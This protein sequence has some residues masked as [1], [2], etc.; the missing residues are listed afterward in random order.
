[1][2]TYEFLCKVCQKTFSVIQAMSEHGKAAIKC[3]HC[4]S[5]HVEQLFS[6]FFAKTES[7]S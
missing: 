7:K 1:M 5:S 6:G 2:P 4:G 3:S